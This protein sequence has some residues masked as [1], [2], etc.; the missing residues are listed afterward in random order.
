MAYLQNSFVQVLLGVPQPDDIH[1]IWSRNSA[2][3][4][5][6][7]INIERLKKNRHGYPFGLVLE[8]AFVLITPS[9]VFQ[10]LNPEPTGPYQIVSWDEAVRPYQAA[11]GFEITAHRRVRG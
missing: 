6:G 1:V 4:P 9:E 7:Q 8:H 11:S 3:F 5:I 10:K 2:D